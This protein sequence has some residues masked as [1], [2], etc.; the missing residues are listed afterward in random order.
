MYLLYFEDMLVLD[1][2]LRVEEVVE[3]MVALVLA[4]MVVV[5]EVEMIIPQVV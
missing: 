1:Y 2:L 4:V 5:V 3:E